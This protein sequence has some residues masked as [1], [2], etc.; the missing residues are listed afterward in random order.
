IVFAFGAWWLG[1]TGTLFLSSTRMIFAAAF[2]RMLPEWAGR[3]SDRRAVPWAALALIMIPSIFLSWLYAYNSDFY[4]LTLDALLGRGTPDPGA[5]RRPF[6]DLPWLGP[7][8]V[9]LEQRVRDRRREHHVDRV[10]RD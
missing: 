8:H 6:D 5:R 3:V 10:P 2:D 9:A 1:W 4:G 7:L